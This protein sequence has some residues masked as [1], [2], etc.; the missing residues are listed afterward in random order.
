MKRFAANP[1][2][3]NSGQLGGLTASQFGQI[4]ANNTYTGT[5][6]FKNTSVS[7]FTIQNAGGTLTALGVDT[8]TGNIS[9]NGVLQTAPTS[10]ASTNSSALNL[11]SGNATGT[12][13]NSGNV[14]ID[15]G[16]ATGTGGQILIGGVNASAIILGHA[17]LGVTIPSSGSLTLGTASSQTGG[18]AFKNSTNANTL[19]LQSGATASNLTFTLPTSDGLGGNCLTTNGSG[20]LSFGTCAGSGS[21]GANAALSNLT[22]V[23]INTT[24]L[25]G[26]AGIVNLGS[27][28]LP[29]GDIFVAGTSAT[30]A[31]NNFRITGTATAART[32]TLPDNS[33]TVCLTSSTNCGTTSGSGSYI[34]NQNA[35]AQVGASFNIDG[36]GT[37]ATLNAT[38]GV[39]TGA[40]AGTKRIDA[41]GNLVNIG[42]IGGTG[43]IGMSGTGQ[44]YVMGMLGLGTVNPQSVLTVANDNWVTS[45]DS[46]GTGVI[47]VFKVNTNNEI[48]VGAAL[49]MDGGIVLPVDAGQVTLV[50]LPISAA[51]TI[52]TPASYTF[53]VGTTNAL[54]VYGE[55]DGA[56]NAQN[57]RVGIGS[58]INPAYTLD[59]S[60]DINTSGVLRTGGTQR[61]DAS[62]NLSNIGTIAATGT[63]TGTTLNGTTGIN[64]GAGAGTQRITSTGQLQNVT[65]DAG[66][67]TTGTLGA[68]RGGTGASSYNGY[69]VVYANSG[70]SALASLTNGT[71]GQCLGA[72]TGL[73]P[74]WV[75]CSSG[76]TLQGDYNNSTSPQIGLTAAG[77]GLLVRDNSTPIGGNLFAVQSNGGVTNYLAVTATGT[78]VASG[79]V[80][81]SGNLTVSSGGAAINGA[82]SGVTTLNTSGNATIGGALTSG[83][84]NGQT[85]GATSTF[86]NVTI[87]GGTGLYLGVAGTTAGTQTF[88]NTTNTN[89]SILKAT[90]PTTGNATFQLP[91]LATG[92]YSICTDAGNC[93]GAGVTI[94]SA[95]NNTAGGTPEIVLNSTNGALDVR[96]AATA[97]GTNLLNVANNAGTTNYF[98]V[99]AA[100]T[101]ITNGLNLSSSGI[102]NG[103]AISGA[104]IATTGNA[105]FS[106]TLVVTSTINSQTIAATSL[107]TNL[108][109]SG[110][111]TIQ[112]AGGLTLGVPSTTSGKLVIASGTSGFTVTLQPASLSASRT[113]TL[114]D[115]GG[116]ICTD[117]GNCNGA[118]TTLQ[119]GYTNSVGG[120]TP[121]IL[122]ENT[123]KG[124]TIADAAA[125]ITGNLFQIQNNANSTQFFSV[126]TSGAAA[127]ALAVAGNATVGGT[128]AVTGTYNGQTISAAANFTG[129]VAVAGATTLSGAL[130]VVS[131]STFTNASSTLNT[132][133]PLSNFAAGGP[134]GTAVATVDTH[135]SFTVNQTTGSQALT[136][137]FPTLTTAGRTIYISNI[138]TAAF[139][140]SSAVINPGITAAYFWNGTAWTSTGI[141]T[142]VTIVG[143]LDSQ[144][145][146]A[147]G[148]VITPN[149][150]YLQSA[151]ATH[152]GLV[153]AVAQTFGGVKTFGG[154]IKIQAPV[155]DTLTSLQV[156]QNGGP[157]VFVVDAND[158]F[159]G[160]GPG[161]AV[162]NA[163][164]QVAGTV[165][166]AG[167][168]INLNNSSN[169]ATNINTGISTG[170]V[171][172]GNASA[173]VNINGATNLNQNVTVASG[174]TLTV[175]GT[176]AI[177]SSVNASAFSVNG[178]VALL[179]ADTSA[180]R[181]TIGTVGSCTI[182]GSPGKFCINQPVAGP[183]TTTNQNNN[184]TIAN[185]VSGI[186]YL[187]VIGISDTSTAVANTTYGQ[188]ID[189]SSGTNT[190]QIVNSLYVKVTANQPG[191]FL[192]LNNGAANVLTV[193]NSGQ[194]TLQ[195]KTNSTSAFQIQNSSAA[196]LFTADTTNERLYVGP[197]AGDTVGALLV[198]GNKTSYSA[199]QTGDPTGVAGGMYY[200]SALGS[201]RCYDERWHDCLETSRN[202]WV[203]K[204]E[205]MGTGTATNYFDGTMGEANSGGGASLSQAVVSAASHPGISTLSTGTGAVPTYATFWLQDTNDYEV[206][207]GVGDY[208]RHE[209]IA[210]IPTLSTS[211]E[212]FVVRTGFMDGNATTDGTDG[213][214]FKYS[215]N[216]NG[217]NWQGVCINNTILTTCDTGTTLAA[218]A[219]YRLEVVV[220]SAGSSADFRI[221]GTSKCTIS[222][223]IPTGSARATSIE[224]VMNKTVGTT[225]RDLYLD[226]T[227]DE[228]QFTTPR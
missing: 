85:I 127:S 91:G 124:V 189:S 24:L 2:S 17:G 37:G 78:S 55:A 187:N 14:T 203:Y 111:Q 180:Y 158:N 34:Q 93:L 25:P 19:T 60:G 101:T 30:P 120:T 216:I 215:D 46:A 214:F 140:I 177:N 41:S 193:A 166:A 102:T 83:T 117:S 170:T 70:G 153:T 122:L 118:G 47:N 90:A 27:A 7:A 161:A 123:R 43:T 181:V 86:S 228:A 179:T 16:S 115:A 132:A 35:G 197:T 224:T 188:F 103:G 121:M 201:F 44:S 191:S 104:S 67:L 73:A 32:L 198:L 126:N 87:Q 135:T 150:I 31:S 138:G 162:P 223:G 217:G 96:D 206:V 53:R 61:L 40:G 89:V 45:I 167:G 106:G 57:L 157:S 64:T 76:A 139:T 4:A 62:G 13:S 50:D 82:I 114:P 221:N 131:G 100:G 18:V 196:A 142:G 110:S 129:T 152:V 107:L 155:T 22:S 88:A 195:N 52:G 226:Y 68:T 174:K 95:Y 186:Q 58:N 183:G 130:N 178:G 163:T 154:D 164:L 9:I 48:Q 12:T 146:S 219:W 26:A 94:Q 63:I 202:K 133:L 136:I 20:L 54:T 137:P 145:K 56:G 108:T 15:S 59:V 218:S 8:T 116:I 81:S 205:F 175:Q 225:N 200:N 80:V 144:T 173:V 79:L 66:I 207:F 49:N 149:T 36:S 92:T 208:W 141:D 211:T 39:N 176:T 84:V 97:I 128:L 112:G 212:R 38:T 119:N 227:E 209:L 147:D 185:T 3:V 23:A 71:T 1:Y 105:N 194:T 113:L 160:I 220:N 199:P 165:N 168:I 99:A 169:F 33:G 65:G 143:A 213:C 210:E 151:D 148:A 109:V 204:N 192:S 77:G 21:G 69:G 156:L 72:S 159:V 171:T 11:Q 5:N 190:S 184:M 172:I 6:L 42:N 75:A 98:S 51:S 29:F 134:I 182:A 28:P 10:V 125:P 222:S 74:T